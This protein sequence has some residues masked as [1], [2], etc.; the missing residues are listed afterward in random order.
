MGSRLKA[1]AEAKAEAKAKAEDE[2]DTLYGSGDFEFDV[3]H[4]RPWP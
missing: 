2:E 3:T 4:A 1:E